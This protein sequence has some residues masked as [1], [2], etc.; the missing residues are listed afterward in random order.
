MANDDVPHWLPG[1]LRIGS[2][3]GILILGVTVLV[4]A[5]LRRAVDATASGSRG[6][7]LAPSEQ[8]PPKQ[9]FIYPQKTAH[10]VTGSEFVAVLRRR[11]ASKFGRPLS[12]ATL[13]VL[14]AHAFLAASGGDNVVC[15]NP[16]NLRAGRF[17]PGGWSVIREPVWRHRRPQ[18]RWA[19]VRAYGSFDAGVNDWLKELPA[20]AVK[21]ATAGDPAAYLRALCAH[22][23]FEAPASVLEPEFVATTR[24]L[25]KPAAPQIPAA[26]APRTV[27]GR[28]G[29]G[30]RHPS[31]IR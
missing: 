11:W 27:V 15:F 26:D 28:R 7:P 21:A 16:V 18:H 25:H 20:S 14:Q 12:A 22:H 31:V 13:A 19:P 24:M 1:W 4:P 3:A 10:P 17:W 9:N 29:Y 30:R 8:T 2:G 5:M 6:D 23:W